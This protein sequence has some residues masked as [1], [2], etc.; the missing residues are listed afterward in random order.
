MTAAGVYT[1]EERAAAL[2]SYTPRGP[3]AATVAA[4]ESEMSDVKLQRNGAF[5]HSSV[6][7]SIWTREYGLVSQVSASPAWLQPSLSLALPS[8]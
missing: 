6:A 5:W 1:A 3:T 4:S 8:P 2:A 7:G